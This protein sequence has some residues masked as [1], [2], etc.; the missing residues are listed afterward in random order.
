[1]RNLPDA[2]SNLPKLPPGAT[3]Q[4]T[5][6]GNPDCQ[7][8]VV[9][10]EHGSSPGIPDRD[11]KATTALAASYRWFVSEPTRILTWPAQ[12]VCVPWGAD[13]DPLTQNVAAG[14]E[15]CVTVGVDAIGFAL[16]GAL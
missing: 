14:G 2:F 10:T 12:S 1:L 4:L 15:G 13:V 11:C 5:G 8:A 7:G 9:W 3:W 6:F 16:G